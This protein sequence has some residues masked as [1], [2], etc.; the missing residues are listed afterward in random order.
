VAWKL[1]NLQLVRPEG[2][3]FYSR[4]GQ[5]TL[6]VFAMTQCLLLLGLYQTYIL[7]AIIT[8]PDP[9]PFK[10][11]NDFI[12]GFVTNK[13]RFVSYYAGHW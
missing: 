13:Y 10:N 2:T 12:E 5:L 1:V 3:P 4:A 9:R 11:A 6:F 7:S 8:P